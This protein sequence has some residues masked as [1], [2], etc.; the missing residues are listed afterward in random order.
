MAR[1]IKEGSFQRSF[2]FL[3]DPLVHNTSEPPPKAIFPSKPPVTLREPKTY[4]VGIRTETQPQTYRIPK[5]TLIYWKDRKK[6]GR[7][8]VRGEKGRLLAEATV[9]F[10]ED[11]E[12]KKAKYQLVR[13]GVPFC[14][15][16]QADELHNATLKVGEEFVILK[17]VAKEVL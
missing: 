17:K 6:R 14:Y 11:V 5:N 7:R 1:R 13:K 8:W 9:V 10:V 4:D 12:N 3:A 16:K 15:A 2:S